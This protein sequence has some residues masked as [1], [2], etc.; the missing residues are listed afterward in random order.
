VRLQHPS[1]SSLRNTAVELYTELPYNAK[2]PE[3]IVIMTSEHFD[4]RYNSEEVLN[5]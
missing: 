1:L 5:W 3:E 4:P 2:F